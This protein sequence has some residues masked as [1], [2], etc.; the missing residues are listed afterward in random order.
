MKILSLHAYQVL[1]FLYQ[2][3]VSL[4]FHQILLSK[5]S[6]GDLKSLHTAVKMAGVFFVI[7]SNQDESYQNL[8]YFY[9]SLTCKLHF[10]KWKN[11]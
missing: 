4:K 1:K 11:K 7:K 8:F 10:Q 3:N 6:T 5:L 2:Q 9:F